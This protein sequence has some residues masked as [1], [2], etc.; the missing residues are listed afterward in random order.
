MRQ[1]PDTTPNR[2][3]PVFVA[4]VLSV[5]KYVT[6]RFVFPSE[7]TPDELRRWAVN[8][9]REK[10]LRNTRAT[11][12]VSLQRERGN[13]CCSV[14]SATTAHEYL[15]CDQERPPLCEL[16]SCNTTADYESRNGSCAA[17]EL[18]KSIASCC[19]SMQTGSCHFM[20]NRP[21]A[22]AQLPPRT[23][24][25]KRTGLGKTNGKNWFWKHPVW[26]LFFFS[27]QQ[28]RSSANSILIQSGAF[29]PGAARSHFLYGSANLRGTAA[30]YNLELM[31]YA[32]RPRW[33]LLCPWINLSDF[34]PAV[35]MDFLLN[36][37]MRKKLELYIWSQLLWRFMAV[38]NV[39]V[40]SCPII[41]NAEATVGQ[42]LWFP[43]ILVISSVLCK[44]SLTVKWSRKSRLLW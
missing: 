30:N 8:K 1:Q 29:H 41:S 32:A 14:W 2:L 34:P 39:N 3:C 25:H 6:V 27:F 10:G 16:L 12:G 44:R 42:P 36:D 7:V 11:A 9:H 35:R 15:K 5:F 26:F 13:S 23:Y 43:V 40:P 31:N 19:A 28:N 20:P 22:P 4:A 17:V 37:F 33:V 21:P 24:V 18:T 38:V